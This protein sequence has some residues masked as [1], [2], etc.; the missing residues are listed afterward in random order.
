MIV[1]CLIFT[2]PCQGPCEKIRAVQGHQGRNA[3]RRAIQSLESGEMKTVSEQ[4]QLYRAYL[5]L[6]IFCEKVLREAD[7]VL[8]IIRVIDRFTVTGATPEMSPTT[9][10][11]IL[12]ISFKSGFLRGKQL[13]AVR[14]KSPNGQD[15]AQMA[16]PIL[17]EGDD[18]RGNAL[19]A[20]INFL[21]DQEGPYWF[22]VYLNEELV[23]RM[24]LRVI[25]Q[26]VQAIG[27]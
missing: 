22:D 5:A 19:I 3:E 15:M 21:V 2:L 25:Y 4:P 26:Q 23:T 17:F 12:V 9:L 7:N 14:P 13:L 11:F 8:S 24:P 20:Q 27:R 10:N 18:D 16:F 6:A 1:T